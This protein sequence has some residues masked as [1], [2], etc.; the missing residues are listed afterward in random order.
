MLSLV[1]QGLRSWKNSK[2][3]ALLAIAALTIGIGSTTA[4]FT[5]VQ[6][7]LLK[8]LPYADPD[9][10]F[11]VLGAWRDRPDKTASS[12]PD[13][14]DMAARVRTVDAF[15]CTTRDSF[16]VTFNGQPL[17]VRG[18]Q[19]SAGLAQSVGVNPVLGRWFNDGKQEPGGVYVVVLANSLWKRLGADP[20]ILG[21]TLSMNGASYT[22]VGV[23]PDFFRFP[24]DAYENDLWAPLNPDTNQRKNRDFRYL[25]C[26]AKLKAGVPR[27]QMED[28]F[29]SIQAQLQREHGSQEEPDTVMVE[30]VLKLVL[31]DIRP[32]LFLLLGAAAA[33]LLISCAN[34]AS[35]LLTRSVAR[36]R[37][38]A[39]RVALGATIW[40]LG[41]QYFSEGLVVA[42]AGAG[43]G[44]LASAGLV[45]AVLALL[46]RNVPRNEPIGMNW[47][48][49]G[50]T[51]GVSVFCSLIFSLAP[52][53]Q[54]GRTPPNEVLSDGTRASAGARSRGLLRVFV[55]AEIALAFGLVAI[56]GL[57]AEHLGTL[58]RVRL[59]FDPAHVLTMNMVAP[60][61][62]YPDDQT[63]A[64]YEARLVDAVRAVPGVES[65]GFTSGLPLAGIAGGSILWLD[66]ESE[67]DFTKTKP[68]GLQFVSPQYFRTLSIPLVAGRFVNDADRDGKTMAVLVNQA[69]ARR[70]W[71][72]GDPLE[73]L[74]RISN[75]SDKETRL[76]VA[77][78]VGDV[79][80]SSLNEPPAPEIYLSFRSV[81]PV[82]MDWVI[83]S[84]LDSGAL[85]RDVRLAVQRVDPEQSIFRERPM[86]EIVAESLSSQ[87]L[88]AFMV[89]FFAISALLLAILGVYGVVSYSV[90]QRT[91]EI[92]TRMALGA[93]SGDLI[94]LVVGGGLK[95]AGI[96]IAAGLALILALARILASAGLNVQFSGSSTLSIAVALITGFTA[97]ACFVPAWQATL[98]SPLIAIRNEPE[99]MWARIG[100]E[101]RRW[102]GK[103]SELAA[104]P[105]ERTSELELLTAIVDSSRQAES[106]S[107]AIRTALSA[108]RESMGAEF[109]V[110]L[111]P[112]FPGEAY[113]CAAASPETFKKEWSLPAD[114]LI[115]GR[116]RH[117]S[118]ALPIASADLE[119]WLRWANEQ[120]PG[121]VAELQT[122]QEMRVALAAAAADK[123]ETVGILLLGAPVNRPPY[124]AV[125][126]RV[127][128]SVGAQLALL[129]E[130]GRL[131]D[132]IVEQE[133]L[134]RDLLVAAEVQKRL[135]PDKLPETAAVH[136]AGLCIP[137]RG[138]GGDYYDF[139]DLGRGQIGIALADVAGKGIAAALVMSVV[140]A[141]LR[142]LAETGGTPLADVAAK[143]NRLLHRST[144]T[145]SYATFFYAQ[146][147]EEK[148]QLRYVNAGHNPPFLLRRG[149]TS[150][151]ELSVGGTII[152]M[153]PIA[154]YEEAAVDLNP[155]DV[156]MAFTDGVSEAHDPKEEEFGDDRLKD[157]L[158]RTAHLPVREMSSKILDELKIWMADAEQFDDLTFMVMKVQ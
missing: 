72:R 57:L 111:A 22:V 59:G 18:T 122:L 116:L 56:G 37:E 97:L 119:T 53:W 137:A 133:R 79:R 29:K 136:C 62:K 8:P 109:A 43:V 63:R 125:E 157:L 91:S 93:T 46:D 98:L 88:Q 141:S 61:T 12:Y 31:E 145:N 153:F 105:S 27:E 140:Q 23:M 86:E 135:F 1:L 34:V 30:S 6:A 158:F 102:A 36:A 148:R 138:V 92:G 126:R 2:G 110:L 156:L 49:L 89:S 60:L 65:A 58:Y 21:K 130:N 10:Y 33:L 83:R 54:A 117:Y 100:A 143:M 124:S 134:K 103:I 80:N 82:E 108:L 95:M 24:V 112:R 123:S 120:A 115:F 84:Q 71:P 104:R 41:C 149:A 151:E 150:I 13:A 55:V 52:L 5:V 66:G 128:R 26:T 75:F 40:Q 17:H 99:T 78:V 11:Y 129:V 68:I 50:F 131:T 42:L 96:G 147:D 9:R 107:G 14:M 77:G 144:G 4:I 139:L 44:A 15:G 69:A 64:N 94:G 113:R 132:R 152:G 28:D 51:L 32:T 127:L 114:A 16:N 39:I 121:H 3:A 25:M 70:F 38:T 73:S 74:V 85:M 45:R 81:S 7:W 19:A 67:P 20:Q 154:R 76:R 48:I 155:G 142:S 146:F 101:S 47:Q 118:A 106:F 35:L 90:R 87:R